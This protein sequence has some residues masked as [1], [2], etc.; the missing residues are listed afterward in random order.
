VYQTVLNAVRCL[1]LVLYRTHH[2]SNILSIVN[3]NSPKQVD[4]DF[5]QNERVELDAIL[6]K[7]GSERFWVCIMDKLIHLFPTR[8]YNWAIELPTEY[9]SKEEGF[10]GVNINSHSTREH[11]QAIV[12]SY[13]KLL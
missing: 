13:N 1:I 7:V 5:L 8:N 4:I 12:A 10:D 11:E 2:S 6:A 3:S 9:Y